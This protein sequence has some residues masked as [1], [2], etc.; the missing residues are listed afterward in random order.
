MSYNVVYG[1][2]MS[3]VSAKVIG[4]VYLG[5]QENLDGESESILDRR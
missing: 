5:F 3:F 1:N 2:K 4:V